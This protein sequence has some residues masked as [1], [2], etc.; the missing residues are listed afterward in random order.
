MLQNLSWFW[1]AAS[2]L[3]F[4]REIKLVKELR[5]QHVARIRRE[6]N[7][8]GL[9]WILWKVEGILKDVSVLWTLNTCVR[10]RAWSVLNFQSETLFLIELALLL[11]PFATYA[12][13]LFIAW[14][15]LGKRMARFSKLV[16]VQYSWR[17]SY[18]PNRI[19]LHRL[20]R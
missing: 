19:E 4:G 7:H 16:R 12:S 8:G 5:C 1:I 2:W 15:D 6:S 9:R 3:S 14:T 20:R 17:S 10:V 11:L 18:A 13:P